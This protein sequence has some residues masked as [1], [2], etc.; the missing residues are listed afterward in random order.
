[1]AYAFDVPFCL[2]SVSFVNTT[3]VHPLDLGVF[4]YVYISLNNTNSYLKAFYIIY[5]FYCVYFYNTCLAQV[6][7]ECFVV[8]N[9]FA[10]PRGALWTLGRFFLLII[11]FYFNI[12][13]GVDIMDIKCLLPVPQYGGVGAAVVRLVL[14]F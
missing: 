10:F 1:M 13:I 14:I 11:L 6:Q 7:S 3:L 4:S 9:T 2:F 8:L 5:I 12:I